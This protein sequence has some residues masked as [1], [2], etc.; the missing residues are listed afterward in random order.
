VPILTLVNSFVGD[1]GS[2][3]LRLFLPGC[4]NDLPDS[5]NVILGKVDI[6]FW[7]LRALT[8]GSEML[9]VEIAVDTDMEV[10]STVRK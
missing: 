10:A 4:F 9:M 5:I 2:P 6:Q 7:H 8:L 1:F 3:F